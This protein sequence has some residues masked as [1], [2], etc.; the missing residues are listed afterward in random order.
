MRTP[1]PDEEAALPAFLEPE[2]APPISK[3]L[4]QPTQESWRV[5]RDLANDQTTLEVINDE[6]RYRLDDIDLEIAARVTER[7]RYSYGSYDS[8][9]GWTEW[10]RS[11]K[12]GDWEVRTLTRTLMTSDP[13][14]FRLRATLD[15]W[16]GETRIFARTW[17]ETIPRDLV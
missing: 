6:G 11:F 9:S 17:D 13:D 8:L 7:Y 12:R 4:I 1:R 15:A 5:I 10:E 16:E 2:G 14:N 3:T